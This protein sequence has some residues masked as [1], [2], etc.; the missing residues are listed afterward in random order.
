MQFLSFVVLVQ[1]IR[2]EEERIETIKT[3]SKPQLIKDILVFS[4]FANFYERFIKNFNRIATL[5][6]SMLQ[7]TD[8][9]EVSP[10]DGRSEIN[11]DTPIADGGVGDT[12]DRNIENLSIGKLVK[13]PNLAKSRN[14]KMTKANKQDFVTA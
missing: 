9:D 12:I 2:M 14:S 3:W 6:T 1:K 7:T 4:S 13:K 10:Q 11:Q 8:K 5:F